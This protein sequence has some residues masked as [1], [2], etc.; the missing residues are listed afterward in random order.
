MIREEESASDGAEAPTRLP[1][2]A[3][4]PD[5]PGRGRR[6]RR[7]GSP[8][9]TSPSEYRLQGLLINSPRRLI[10]KAGKQEGARF[11]QKF[12]DF[13]LSR[14]KIS[15][16]V[17]IN[18]HSLQPEAGEGL[19]TRVSDPGKAYAV[20]DTPVGTEPDPPVSLEDDG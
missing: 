18:Q 2:K 11:P 15:G 3:A 7:D 1:L 16:E 20:P 19:E 17:A 9:R 14:F 10:G 12:P 4:S 8:A 13:S 6:L 5:E